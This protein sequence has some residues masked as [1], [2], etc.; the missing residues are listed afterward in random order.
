[1][2]YAAIGPSRD[3]AAVLDIQSALKSLFSTLEPNDNLTDRIFLAAF[4]MDRN[5]AKT[6]KGKGAS[7]AYRPGLPYR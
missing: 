4:R 3:A 5:I 1:M 6:A 2:R 7:V